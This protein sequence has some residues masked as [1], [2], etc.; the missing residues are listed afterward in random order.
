M[1]YSVI[2]RFECKSGALIP[3]LKL[4]RKCWSAIVT[5]VMWDVS[6]VMQER[7]NIPLKSCPWY[8][9]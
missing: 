8:L 3:E 2:K 1:H 6:S 4:Q 5:S 7:Q 9:I